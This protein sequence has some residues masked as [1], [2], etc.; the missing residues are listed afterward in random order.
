[1]IADFLDS[2]HLD[3]ETWFGPFLEAGVQ[4]KEQLRGL[5]S[6]DESNL[7]WFLHKLC[8]KHGLQMNLYDQ[9]MLKNALHEVASG[10]L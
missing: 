7:E 4:G 9:V 5:A 1:M 10:S 6:I 2:A 8:V 3:H